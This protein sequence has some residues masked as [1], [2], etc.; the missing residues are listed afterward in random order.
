MQQKPSFSVSSSAISL[1]SWLRDSCPDELVVVLDLFSYQPWV[2]CL[3]LSSLQVLAG[4]EK[5]T[6]AYDLDDAEAEDSDRDNE[7]AFPFLPCDAVEGKGHAHDADREFQDISRLIPEEASAEDTG[8][9]AMANQGDEAEPVNLF[10][11][12]AS[13]EASVEGHRPRHAY[14]HQEAFLTLSHALDNMT[15]EDVRQDTGMAAL[16]ELASFGCS[17]SPIL[18]QFSESQCFPSTMSLICRPWRST[19]FRRHK[20]LWNRSTNSSESPTEEA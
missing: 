15:W 20:Y 5:G 17:F 14:Y 1:A 13:S 4:A 10:P 6:L 18:F 19:V 8:V 3:L 7:V 16:N 12:V 11:L 9:D 2:V